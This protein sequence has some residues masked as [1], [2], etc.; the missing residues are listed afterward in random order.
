[1]TRMETPEEER[2]PEERYEDCLLNKALSFLGRSR[3][4]LSGI[5]RESWSIFRTLRTQVKA[6]RRTF[7]FQ[8]C[9]VLGMAERTPHTVLALQ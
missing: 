5:G 3:F 9:K 1:M 7:F 6:W 8:A 4:R 2:L